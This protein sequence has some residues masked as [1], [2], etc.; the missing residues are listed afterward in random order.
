MSWK[1]VT[2]GEEALSLEQALTKLKEA[3]CLSRNNSLDSAL[4]DHFD[5]V[6]AFFQMNKWSYKFLSA[7][8]GEKL[9][10]KQEDQP[11]DAFKD[12]SVQKANQFQ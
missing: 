12:E 2:K 5:E 7:S 3:Y 10:N 8:S 9:E 6:E 1:Q 4:L 11:M